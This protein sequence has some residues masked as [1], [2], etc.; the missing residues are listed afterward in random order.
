MRQVR[1]NFRMEEAMTIKDYAEIVFLFWV[2]G[3][4]TFLVVILV[5]HLEKMRLI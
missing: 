3:L 4:A 2:L 1:N 5:K